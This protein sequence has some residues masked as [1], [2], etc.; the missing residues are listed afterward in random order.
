[1]HGAGLSCLH[2]VVDDFS[3]IAYAELFPDEHAGEPRHA[4]LPK[5]I[6]NCRIASNAVY[7][8]FESL[9][10]SNQILSRRPRSFQSEPTLLSDSLQN[11][12]MAMD[13]ART[14]PADFLHIEVCGN[15]I[16]EEELEAIATQVK[17]A[18][19]KKMGNTLRE[20]IALKAPKE[21]LHSMA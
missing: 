6:P 8:S 4:A 14:F 15:G 19:Y 13:G 21:L 7:D 17:S 20:S 1:M 12:S 18:L 2:L 3:H 10:C 9:S 11:R 5:T 16:D